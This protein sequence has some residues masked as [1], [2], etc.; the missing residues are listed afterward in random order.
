M[1]DL[2]ILP[3]L[4]L[5]SSLLL[6]G[7]SGKGRVIPSGSTDGNT[8][9]DGSSQGGTSQ[10]GTSQGGSQDGGSEQGGETSSF[11]AQMVTDM[12]N[13]LGFV[14]PDYGV[15]QDVEYQEYDETYG[16]CFYDYGATITGAEYDALLTDKHG[17]VGGYDSSEDWYAYSLNED[18][19]TGEC[20][21]WFAFFDAVDDNNESYFAIQ[22]D[23]IAGESGGGDSGEEGGE[24]T[25]TGDIVTVTTVFADLGWANES[26]HESVELDNVITATVLSKEGSQNSGKFYTSGNEWRIYQS[27][28]ASLEISA[29]SGYSISS[30]KITYS[31]KNTGALEGAASNA[32]VTVNATSKTFAVIN[33]GSATNGQVKITQIE[34]KYAAI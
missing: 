9:L 19:E 5:S 11:P 30:I 21:A 34:V 15:S 20:D 31:V 12:Q 33:T 13:V 1:K 14:L 2:K 27:E 23:G 4:L 24:V 29:S 10:G 8:S 3:L 16:Y 26:R 18:T 17:F 6:A 7:C 28:E 25:P 22:F 32:V